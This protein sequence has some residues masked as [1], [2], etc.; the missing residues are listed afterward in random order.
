MFGHSGILPSTCRQKSYVY[1]F[2]I[3]RRAT[4]NGKKAVQKAFDQLQ[5]PPLFALEAP[6]PLASGASPQL[7]SEEPAVA[8]TTEACHYWEQGRTCW[9]FRSSSGRA[10]F[11]RPELLYQDACHFA[12]RGAKCDGSLCKWLH[13][14]DRVPPSVRAVVM[15]YKARSGGV[16]LMPLEATNVIFQYVIGQAIDCNEWMAALRDFNQVC[17]SPQQADIIDGGA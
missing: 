5:A 17:R 11:H 7:A 9:K 3:K 14:G 12:L 4:P 8:S 13:V 16:P 6:P 1:V 10:E 2:S 15:A